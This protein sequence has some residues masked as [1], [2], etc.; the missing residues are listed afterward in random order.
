MSDVRKQLAKL[1]PAKRQLLAR[2]VRQEGPS[3]IEPT[4]RPREDGEAVPL[5]CLQEQIWTHEQLDPGT[6]MYH[7]ACGYRLHGSLDQEALQS[8][9]LSV[10]CRNNALRAIFPSVDGTPVQVFASTKSIDM[11]VKDLAHLDPMRA[12][13][14]AK[15]L[16]EDTVH[17]PFDLAQGP[18]YRVQLLKIASSEYIL[19]FVFHHIIFD[20]WSRDLLLRE[21]I[22]AYEATIN[23]SKAALPATKISYGDF[24]VW[25][26]RWLTTEEAGHQTAFW[27]QQLL[28]APTL[29]NLTTDRPRTAV[30]TLD[31]AIE[32][33]TV[34]ESLSAAI[35]ALAAQEK[36][37]LFTLL[38]SAFSILLHRYSAQNDML[39]GTPSL[40]RIRDELQFLIG[41]F[42]NTI[43]LRTRVDNHIT[44]R[45][46]LAQIR[47]TTIEA[48]A[49]QDTPFEHVVDVLRPERSL[50]GPPL[51]QVMFDLEAVPNTELRM[52]DLVLAPYDI[53]RKTAIFDIH[54][55]VVNRP[56]LALT[57]SYK[58]DLFDRTTISRML[59]HYTYLL[60]SIVAAPNSHIGGLAFHL[61][62][63]DT[64]RGRNGAT[65]RALPSA[66]TS[67]IPL[68]EGRVEEHPGEPALIL[69]DLSLT[70]RELNALANQFARY[71]RALGA[72][73]ETSIGVCFERS[74]NMVAA[75]L[76]ILKAG[77]TYVPLD[78]AYPNERLA[79]MS[80]DGHVEILLLDHSLA[81]PWPGLSPTCR[82]VDVSLAMPA[83]LS[84]ERE[85]LGSHPASEQVAYIMYTSGSTGR[86]KGVLVP[87]KALAIH[88][89]SASK[90]F[91][92]TPS[93]RVLQFASMSFD[94]ALEQIF[95]ALLAGASIF[96]RGPLVPSGRDLLDKI[97][98]QG[99]T[100]V[101][102]P[103][104]Y[105]E[106][107][108]REWAL[109]RDDSQTHQLKLLIVGGEAMRPEAL[110]WWHKTPLR[111]ARLLNAYG[112][113]ETTI[114][115]TTF[116]VR[117]KTYQR[118]PIG[119]AVGERE[120]H[121]L[122]CSL[123]AVPQGLAG[124]LCIGGPLLARGYAGDPALTAEKF[125]PDSFGAVPGARLYRTGDRGR[126]SD[127]G[128]IEFLGRKDQQVKIRGFRIELGEIEAVLHSHPEVR[129]AVV[130][131]REDVQGEKKLIAYVEPQRS[132]A[133]EPE[134]LKHFLATR[135]PRHMVPP[136]V[137]IIDKLR[138]G[139]NGKIDSKNLPPPESPR[140]GTDEA[141]T[142]AEK[143]LA[144]IW[145]EVLALPNCGVY[146]N[147]FALGGD[148]ILAI[149][150]IARAAK[151]GLRI[152][153]TEF[154]QNQTIR[155]LALA[156]RTI[157]SGTLMTADQVEVTGAVPLSPVQR[158]FLDDAPVDPFHFN[159]AFLFQIP[160]GINPDVM[161][162]ALHR[163]ECHHDALRM[164]FVNSGAIWRQFNSP[165]G[166]YAAFEYADLSS[167]GEAA[168][169]TE[170][171]NIAERLQTGL[172]LESGPLLRA[173]QFDFGP[174]TP[175][176]LLLVVHHLVID[177]VSWHIL[178][179]DLQHCYELI[180]AGKSVTLAAKTTS[181]KA[182]SEKLHAYAKGTDVINELPF[183]ELQTSGG[184]G[185]F[186][187]DFEAEQNRICDLCTLAT[188]LAEKDT[189]SF[190]LSAPNPLGLGANAPLLAALVRA[191][192]QWSGLRRLTV[193]IEGHG[194]AHLFDD[195]DLSRTIGW[196]TSIFP[197]RLI[198]LGHDSPADTL[199]RTRQL[200]EKV[201]Y[202]GVG[203][204]ILRYLRGDQ[205][206]TRLHGAQPQISFNFL[207]RFD[208]TNA[209]ATTFRRRS[210][211]TGAHRSPHA[212]A[213]Y[214]LDVN[215][216]VLD[217]KLE[218]AW[219][220]GQKLYK[221]QT[222]ERLATSF[223]EELRLQIEASLSAPCGAM[224][225][226]SVHAKIAPRELERALQRLDAT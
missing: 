90:Q 223:L 81:E 149:K 91:G 11:A 75:M 215:A 105:W 36:T 118:M 128:D 209:G 78:P 41:L 16:V 31:G 126:L 110:E 208:Q 12:E 157:D 5:S 63:T 117:E 9:I 95:T 19:V 45:E 106:Q 42:A 111:S 82:V 144:A 153:A 72:T 200:L 131:V 199:L 203:Y 71:L 219:T 87:H 119:R 180:A 28:G 107:V 6:A 26:R 59:R 133:L 197:L 201:P 76:G 125:I 22:A 24:A 163:I 123:D 51:L 162:A 84:L 48:T 120:I 77:S 184:P 185:T 152:T 169:N 64:H 224:A 222:I 74:V 166:V 182:W 7:I 147:F 214:L 207:G 181:F 217:G 66:V 172:N 8:T 148:S 53:D 177:T 70:Y 205:D 54:L 142:P 187:V 210:E 213:R 138:L 55:T 15:G 165:C 101:N 47:R 27:K 170:I 46:L 94:V 178:L 43:A 2:R 158:W 1:S 57:A 202:G 190:L 140:P 25:Q 160:A 37:T 29:I 137:V 204:G 65:T 21:L 13:A 23:G 183:W 17:Q 211:P 98:T 3:I 56:S 85:N 67:V 173:A 155:D 113:T 168:Q 198:R 124:E 193:A 154:Y 121:I 83:I 49:N 10:A 151:A 61:A 136:A 93:D 109:I 212:L 220:F 171:H 79:L 141:Q 164:R 129:L 135:L 225:V 68:F 99:L 122:D 216:A 73:R 167:Y 159:Q 100:V 174:N 4:L 20:G 103:T 134:S 176:R 189:K 145:A 179:E 195:V 14:E 86:P 139:V 60:E 97:F 156:A 89:L 175:G 52:G 40:G 108:T 39:V 104:S 62:E 146:D 192:G 130:M 196:F 18:L 221:Q 150:M 30:Q 50:G 143:A 38:L 194:R 33:S 112:P 218:V 96:L 132:A 127:E 58:T 92:I 44:F 191:I 34:S 88:A 80:N 32:R 115:A 206:A 226:N 116:E 161:A 114:T 188:S 102:L 69:D 35:R 186:P